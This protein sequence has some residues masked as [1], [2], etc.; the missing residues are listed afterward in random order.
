SGK[1]SWDVMEMEYN[2]AITMAEKGLL[3]EID[4]SIVD[5]NKIV[6]ETYFDHGVAAVFNTMVICYDAEKFGDNPPK[7][8]KD[9]FDVERFPGPRCIPK[10][11]NGI[12]EGA[13]LADG[14]TPDQLYPIDLDRALKKIAQL[15]PH[16]T[17]VWG[18]GAESQQVMMD[19]DAVMGV[20]WGTRAILVDRETEQ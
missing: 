15:L 2:S 3:G 13:L 20:I 8:W 17:S 9:F 6:D 1:I 14:V 18:S 7:T 11:M 16:V 5:K 12:L 4:F 10:Y 19:G